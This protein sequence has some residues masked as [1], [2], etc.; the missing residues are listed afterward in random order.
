MAAAL[1]A[2]EAWCATGEQ[3]TATASRGTAT[4]GARGTATV[5]RVVQHRGAGGTATG[6]GVVR[7]PV[8]RA[9]RAARPRKRRPRLAW[10]KR[11][12]GRPVT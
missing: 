12:S 3:W 5:E 2:V 11:C 8:E 10:W 7:Q 1:I 4:G 6:G 9:A